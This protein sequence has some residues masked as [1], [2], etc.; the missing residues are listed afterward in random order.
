MENFLTDIQIENL[1]RAPKRIPLEFDE[2]FDR[3]KEKRGH[4]EFDYLLANDD[5]S[6]FIIRLRQS[7]HQSLNFSAMLAYQPANTFKQIILTRYNGKSHDHCNREEKEEP[8][9]DFHIHLATEKYQRLRGRKPEHYAT[10][11]D[12]YATLR[13]AFKCLIDDCNVSLQEDIQLKMF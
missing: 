10:K 9:Y 13:E 12:R 4:K 2:F 7:T 1:I 11:T 6:L 5:G 3:L 8:F